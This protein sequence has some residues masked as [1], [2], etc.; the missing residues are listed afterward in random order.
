VQSKLASLLL[1]TKDFTNCNAVLSELLS[2][3]RLRR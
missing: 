2:E 3:V 1:K